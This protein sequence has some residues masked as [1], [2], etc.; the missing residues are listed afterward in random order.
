MENTME[1]KQVI[2]QVM[3]YYLPRGAVQYL[4]Q[5]HGLKVT[6]RTVRNWLNSGRLRGEKRRVELLNQDVW[7]VSGEEIDRAVEERRVPGMVG[8]PT[9]D[10]KG[11]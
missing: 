3:S 11:E 6:P 5:V 2:T 10:E 9:F 7:H 4:F 8:N 1:A